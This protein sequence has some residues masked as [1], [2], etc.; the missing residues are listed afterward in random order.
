MTIWLIEVLHGFQATKVLLRNLFESKSRDLETRP[1]FT[2][3]NL[4]YS[5]RLVTL[6]HQNFTQLLQA[7][8][9]EIIIN[10]DDFHD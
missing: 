5:G 3:Q 8:D 1:E 2:L 6:R 4:M 10:Q 9:E 7:N